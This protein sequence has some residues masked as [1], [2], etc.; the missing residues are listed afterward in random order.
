MQN[1]E[2][3][4]ELGFQLTPAGWLYRGKHQ[5]F[6]AKEGYDKRFMELFMVSPEIDT[7]PLSP[8]KGMHFWS[9]VKDCC[10]DGSVKRAIDKYDLPESQIKRGWGVSIIEN[11]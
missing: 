6:V 11:K 7:R 9:Y 2:T 10:S 4:K 5:K 1:I 3:I 8:R